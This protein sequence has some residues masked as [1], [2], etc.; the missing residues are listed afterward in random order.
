M[1]GKVSF[2]MMQRCQDALRQQNMTP[3]TLFAL[4][5]CVFCKPY[6]VFMSPINFEGDPYHTSDISVWPECQNIS[7]IRTLLSAHDFCGWNWLRSCVWGRNPNIGQSVKLAGR[8]IVP[9]TL[10]P[11]IMRS[12]FACAISGRNPNMAQSVQSVRFSWTHS[13]INLWGEIIGVRWQIT[14]RYLIAL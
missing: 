1:W 4:R 11:I 7:I 14:S 9:L 2:A 8:I 10:E 13:S 6:L 5:K 3:G 12:W